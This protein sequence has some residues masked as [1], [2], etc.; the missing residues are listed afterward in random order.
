[1]AGVAASGRTR[2]AIWNTVA[3]FGQTMGFLLK[4]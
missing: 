3:H 4:S 1:M 2:G